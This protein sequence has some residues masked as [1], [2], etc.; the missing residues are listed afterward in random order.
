MLMMNTNEA[1]ISNLFSPTY[2]SDYTFYF[3]ITSLI[4]TVLTLAMTPIWSVVTKALVEK[5]YVWIKKLYRVLKLIGLGAVLLEF[6]LVPILQNIMDIWLGENS[7]TVNYPT[8]IAF[9]CFGSVFI[10]TGILSTIVCGMTRMKLQTVSYSIAM[11]LRFALIYLLAK[12]GGN[13][14]VVV[15]STV[16]VLLPY[17]IIQHIDLNV[18]FNKKIKETQTLQSSES[19]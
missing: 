1:I 5:N 17:C 8:A 7:I 14:D 10:Y 16:L 4:S 11:V 13:W 6:L 3:K 12:L 15:W 2:T 18:Y 9:A 19:I